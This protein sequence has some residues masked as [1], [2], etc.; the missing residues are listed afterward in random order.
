MMIVAV[1]V[2]IAIPPQVAVAL[3]AS[4]AIVQATGDAQ[5]GQAG[6]AKAGG[7][8]GEG[9]A[10]Q[11]GESGGSPGESELLPVSELSVADPSVSDSPVSDVAALTLGAVAALMRAVERQHGA[12]LLAF[13]TGALSL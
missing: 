10:G 8:A 1:I 6:A 3:G 11:A 13:D 2:G 12:L 9:Q 5:A 7:Q 4:L